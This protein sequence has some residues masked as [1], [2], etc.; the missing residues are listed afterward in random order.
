VGI[1]RRCQ[2]LDYMVERL[3]NDE[4]EVIWKEVVVA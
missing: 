1:L 3:M 2:L 4:L